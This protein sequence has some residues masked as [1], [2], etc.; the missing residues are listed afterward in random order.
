[1]NSEL[2]AKLA[3]YYSVKPGR[4]SVMKLIT[5]SQS[6]ERGTGQMQQQ[7]SIV[8]AQGEDMGGELLYL[9]LFGVRSLRLNQPTLSLITIPGLQIDAM[10]PDRHFEGRFLVF[11]AEQHSI[12]SC[13]CHDFC[14]AIG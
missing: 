10:P 5:L 2:Q 9:E 11:D 3:E 4:F 12:F 14:V 1:M 8:L 6:F 7:L 13:A